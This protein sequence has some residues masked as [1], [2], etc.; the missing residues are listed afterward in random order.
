[1]KAWGV[2]D[3]P[4]AHSCNPQRP[5]DVIFGVR[6]E[7]PLGPELIER[8]RDAG[9]PGLE[10]VSQEA[11]LDDLLSKF[12]AS[13]DEPA[14]E[15]EERRPDESR[16]AYDFSL[17][18]VREGEEQLAAAS[19]IKLRYTLGPATP[20]FERTPDVIAQPNHYLDFD[21][22]RRPVGLSNDH[23][24]YLGELGLPAGSIDGHPHPRVRVIDTGCSG[25]S[26]VRFAANIL[27]G[28]NDVSDDHGHGSMVAAIIDSCTDGRGSF[29]IF[30]VADATRKPTEWE[31][32]QALSVGPL[33]PVVNMSLSLGFQGVNC[34]K[35]GRQPVSARTSVFEERLRELAEAGVLVVAAAG[36]ASSDRVAY[37]SRFS[38][39]VAT[40]AW[41]GHPPVLA[42]YSNWGA[43]DQAGAPHPH[44]YLCPGGDRDRGEGPAVDSNGNAVDGTSYA[45]AYMTGLLATVWARNSACEEGCAFCREHVLHIVE[46]AADASQKWFQAA[47]H[48]Q[49]LAAMP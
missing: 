17:L 49:G 28:G 32:L 22:P 43:V 5:G 11:R 30:K 47:Q 10:A 23:P 12:P 25:Q 8:A 31:V 14:E 16:T 39:A 9:L 3:D 48:G 36:N 44:V 21:D 15:R 19:L 4:P 26:Q 27:D 20:N 33:P 6:R 2:N 41:S 38:S 35:C 24:R 7:D 40:L 46:G 18:S 29:E 34:T 42:P 1:M 13:E 45:T 37:P